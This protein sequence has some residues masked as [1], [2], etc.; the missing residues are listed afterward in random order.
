MDLVEVK[1]GVVSPETING[2]LHQYAVL[3]EYFLFM[4]MTNRIQKLIFRLINFH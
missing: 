3:Y 4:P 2:R 1:G